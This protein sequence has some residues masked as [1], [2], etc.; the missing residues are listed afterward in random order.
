MAF[1]LHLTIPENSPAGQVVQRLVLAE[2]VTPEQAVTRI[3]TDAAK[4]HGKKTPAQ[5]LIGAFSSP[6][7]VTMIDEG[8][9]MARRLRV[10]DAK[11]RFDV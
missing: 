6:E 4:Q 8:M 3:L 10:I 2:H 7:D 1:D 11:R 9:D 5:E